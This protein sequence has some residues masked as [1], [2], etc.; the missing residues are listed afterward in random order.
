[1]TVLVTICSNGEIKV[2]DCLNYLTDEVTE[3][4][5]LGDKI[6][7]IN[8]VK[9]NS[10]LTSHCAHYFKRVTEQVVVEETVQKVSEKKAPTKK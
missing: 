3:T 6:Q 5:D 2:W 10:R 7:P 1:M 9:T 8:V 4:I